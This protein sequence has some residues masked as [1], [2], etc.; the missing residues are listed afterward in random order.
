MAKAKIKTLRLE[1][2]VD[3]SPFV[4]EGGKLVGMNVGPD[5]QIYAVIALKELDYRLDEG[6][7]SFVK[8]VPD[9]PQSYRVLAFRQGK[10]TL[11]V[12]LPQVRLN[13][14]DIQPLPQ[15]RFLLVCHRSYRRAEDDYDRNGRIYSCQ[16]QPLGSILLGD[17]IMDVQATASGT[18]WTSY[19]DEGIFGNYGWGVNPIGVPGLIAW[20]PSGEKLYQYEPAHGL[21]PIFDCYA[22]NVASECDVW[23]YYYTEFP[24]VHLHQGEIVA[25]WQP[26]VAGSRALAVKDQLVLFAGAYTRHDTFFLVQLNRDGTTRKLR[27]F[28]LRN[29]Q[30]RIIRRGHTVGRGDALYVEYHN[31][32]YRCDVETAAG[33]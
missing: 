29:E 32:I 12:L 26:P 19:F 2:V 13:I 11:D 33:V 15:D 8:T 18:I 3:L 31:R 27:R 17:G 21:E 7:A 14:H 30:G 22:M 28:A 25:H 23:I 16:G 1:P 10:K 9:V 4:Q 5:G 24:L 6:G 20:N